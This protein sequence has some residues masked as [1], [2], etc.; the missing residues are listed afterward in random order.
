MIGIYY[1][2]YTGSTELP[3]AI[4]N[5]KHSAEDWIQVYVPKHVKT[6]IVRTEIN[7]KAATAYTIFTHEY[8]HLTN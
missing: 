2:V 4:F 7:K 5:K 6:T 1:A 8:K 3:R